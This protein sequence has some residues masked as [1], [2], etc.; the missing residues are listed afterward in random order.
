M[1]FIRDQIPHYPPPLQS[2][3]MS[4]TAGIKSYTKRA[5]DTRDTPAHLPQDPWMYLNK[6][7]TAQLVSIDKLITRRV[8]DIK[9]I[10]KV[11]KRF[12]AVYYKVIPKRDP[13]SVSANTDGTY[14]VIDGSS[15]LNTFKA[16]G[17]A[18]IAVEII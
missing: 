13:I 7:T 12:L 5:I 3:D 4:T 17:W 6:T 11:K 1:S 8:T 14:L 18:E 9:D 10:D 15:T 16:M 2:E